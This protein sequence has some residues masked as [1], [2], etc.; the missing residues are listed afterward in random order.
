ML[1]S[2]RIRAVSFGE[3]EYRAWAATAE[4]VG[5][6]WHGAP[7]DSLVAISIFTIPSPSD[8]T[9]LYTETIASP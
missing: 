2:P 7:A 3:R 9:I 1:S 5:V 4:K 8:T 6:P